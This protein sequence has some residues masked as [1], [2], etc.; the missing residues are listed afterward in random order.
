MDEEEKPVTSVGH[1]LPSE[2]QDLRKDEEP[3]PKSK[4]PTTYQPGLAA[5]QRPSEYV[6]PEP[7]SVDRR[8]IAGRSINTDTSRMSTG[9][10]KLPSFRVE[11]SSVKA[12]LTTDDRVSMRQTTDAKD[13]IAINVWQKGSDGSHRLVLFVTGLPDG[14]GNLNLEVRTRNNKDNLP[15]YKVTTRP[16]E[17]ESRK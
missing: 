4:Y 9:K 12:D 1:G 6:R 2:L 10:A 15:I 13:G 7:K 8:I 16:S 17:M 3:K 11:L 5:P 14:E